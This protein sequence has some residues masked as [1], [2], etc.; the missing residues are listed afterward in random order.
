MEKLKI[1]H[2]KETD[3]CMVTAQNECV[4][5]SGCSCCSHTHSHNHV[6]VMSK[7]TVMKLIVSLVALC[8]DFFFDP[9]LPFEMRLSWITIA[10]CGLPA[11]YEGF[12]S[13]VVEHRIG[14]G[15]LVALAITASV[16]TK[17]YFA[18]AEIALLMEIGEKLEARTFAK[19][20]KGIERLVKLTPHKARIV[21]ASGETIIPAESVK[22]GDVIR[23]FA[24]ENIPV[25]GVIIDGTTSVDQSVLTGESVPVDKSIGDE[26]YSGTINRFGAFEMRAVHKAED[27]SIARMVKLV[28][29]ASADKTEI[30]GIA[31]KM[32]SWIVLIALASAIGTWMY[33]GI[34][35]RAVTILVVFCPCALILATPTAIMAAIGNLTK[36]SY[37]VKDGRAMEN[38]SRIDMVV[39]DKTGT[40]TTGEIKV[41]K[42]VSTSSFSEKELYS[43]VAAAES[44]S[45]HPIGKAVVASYCE[46]F[47]KPEPPVD[48]VLI[49]GRGIRAKVSGRD[50]IVGN[51][52]MLEE[53]NI[54]F[55][56]TPECSNLSSE[57]KSIIYVAVD[58]S[59]AGFIALSD[60]IKPQSMETI[61]TLKKMGITPIMLTGDHRG[62]A[63]YVAKMTGI[64][65]V[66]AECTPELKLEEIR[67]LKDKG[68]K[69]SMVG[70]G[71]NDAAALAISDV[72]IAM[73]EI[74]SDIAIDAADIAQ[75][76]D[77]IAGLPGLFS[78][79]RKMMNIVKVN[80]G[81]SIAL[82]IGATLLAMDGMLNPLLGALVHNL[83][84]VAV[85]LNSTRLLRYKNK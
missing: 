55:T 1:V 52:E 85:I 8:A 36:K 18:A 53:S 80:I 61:A 37:L 45:E 2:N 82:N 66:V 10:L 42:I 77:E 27:S 11:V 78:I 65:Q 49:P 30:A 16:V 57:G 62:S 35:L 15:F 5:D 59:A 68:Y 73:A 4:I 54:Y 39:L 32:A 19:A 34:L 74:G 7:S 21:N 25:D 51:R 33:T 56:E 71:V 50:I 60:T 69:V 67:K 63:S 64:D 13:L 6:D 26:V 84:A 24:G 12:K 17:E 44:N 72:G 22:V 14:D 58:G 83:G 29:S 28:K 40:I 46:S 20:K 48:F 81:L 70:D 38:L 75:I 9:V 31:D 79:S 3:G 43:M 76:N 23:V 41:D 47:G